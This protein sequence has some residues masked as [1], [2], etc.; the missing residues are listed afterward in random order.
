MSAEE[1]S[2]RE[3]KHWFGDRR[4]STAQAYEEQ[5]VTLMLLDTGYVAG[6]CMSSTAL[7]RAAN[8]PH[9]GSHY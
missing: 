5:I 1:Q 6:V 7:R 8:R 4:G 9:F 3:L 2:F